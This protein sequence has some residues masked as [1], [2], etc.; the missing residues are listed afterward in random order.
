LDDLLDNVVGEIGDYFGAG[1]VVFG[2]GLEKVLVSEFGFCIGV[3]FG[4]ES[5]EALV[6]LV[7]GDFC[8][9]FLHEVGEVAEAGADFKNFVSW[10]Y[11]GG[12]DYFLTFPFVEEEVL[13]EGAL[14]FKAVLL[15]ELLEACEV[16]EVYGH[17]RRAANLMA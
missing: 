13:A 3:D 12:L 2:I 15:E 10:F 17:A 11:I 4:P 14:G 6:D 1:G 16:V 9:C 5:C 8:S 7:G